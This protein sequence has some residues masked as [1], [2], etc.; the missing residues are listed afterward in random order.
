[1]PSYSG[2]WSLPAQF[3]A[4]GQGL[5][6]QSPYWISTVGNPPGAAFGRRVAVDSSGNIYTCGYG[7]DGTGD[8]RVVLVKYNQYG[9]LQW[10]KT[11]NGSDTDQGYAVAVDS[12]GNIYVTGY[13]NPN[14]SA[15]YELL[16]AKYNSS[17]VV[18][19]QRKLSGASGSYDVGTA[20]AV[21]S[22]ANVYIAGNVETSNGNILIA[23]Y[24]ASGTIQWQRTL[25]SADNDY[26]YGIALDSSANVYVCG[27]NATGALY[28]QLAKY[29]SSGTIQWQRRLGS[30][31][32]VDAIGQGTAVDSSGN[33]YVCGYSN[34]SGT[35]DFNIA[36]YDT[37]G[38][39]QWQRSLGGASQE[40]GRDVAVDSSGNVYVVGDN[41]ATAG[42][43][44]AKYDTSGTI[45][46][47]R[48]FYL[49]AGGAY[50][51]GKGIT[52]DASGNM[53][54]AA[55]SYYDYSMM[56]IKLPTDGSLTGTYGIYTYAA[57]SLT[58]ATSSLTSSTSSLT[59]ASG[60]YT[61]STTS[62]TEANGGF[63]VTRTSI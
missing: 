17:G 57:S 15:V 20:I 14:T 28:F 36:K 56:T 46:W 22:S 31:G 40:L 2:V 27:S 33:M 34:A 1:M 47:Q 21:D 61:D 3:Q 30:G 13:T 11:L 52:V 29:N 53:Y 54:I 7:Y 44:I 43:Q 8:E 32:A 60:S 16:V 4:V 38:T 5:W 50:L 59:D 55:T 51:F 12:S 18:Q 63:T 58:S 49:T 35:N 41:A 10:Q 62:L 45:Q 26:A 48:S 25:S 39:I 37:S 23:K 42:I 6:P 19:W 24:N 9:N